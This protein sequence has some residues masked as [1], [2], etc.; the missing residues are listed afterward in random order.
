MVF[1]NNRLIQYYG[2]YIN[3]GFRVH[4][5]KIFKDEYLPARTRYN[6]FF[7]YVALLAGLSTY[8]KSVSILEIKYLTEL[9][10]C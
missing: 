10:F 1:K 9:R 2:S 8:H 6:Q 4:Y 3:F 7:F 5:N